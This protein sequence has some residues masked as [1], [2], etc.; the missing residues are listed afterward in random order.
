MPSPVQMGFRL[1]DAAGSKRAAQCAKERPSVPRS[2]KRNV[3]TRGTAKNAPTTMPITA[4]VA[5]EGA[6][7]FMPATAR[8]VAG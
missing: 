5:G 4:R 8:H 6:R 2:V 1:A 3:D 7:P